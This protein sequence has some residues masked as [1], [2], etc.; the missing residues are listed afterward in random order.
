MSCRR[1]SEDKERR[2]R[3]GWYASRRCPNSCPKTQVCSPPDLGCPWQSRHLRLT[4]FPPLDPSGSRPGGQRL[5][6]AVHRT[7]AGHGCS[8]WSD[9]AL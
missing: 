9:L 3:L 4:P 7:Q 6:V 8:P 2:S 5:G 1:A